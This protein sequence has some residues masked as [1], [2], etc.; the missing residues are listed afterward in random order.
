MTVILTRIVFFLT[1]QC[2]MRN[3]RSR[4]NMRRPFS[5]H[6]LSFQLDVKNLQTFFTDTMP[7]L[8]NCAAFTENNKLDCAFV[9]L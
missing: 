5:C 2:C 8:L 6:R 7:S 1:T 9:V 4:N 3:H